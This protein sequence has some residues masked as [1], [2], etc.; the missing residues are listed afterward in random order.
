[1]NSKLRDVH[2]QNVHKMHG[3]MIAAGDVVVQALGKVLFARKILQLCLKCM[4]SFKLVVM[5]T[6]INNIQ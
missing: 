3:R 4:V 1:M 6:V 2:K 5:D